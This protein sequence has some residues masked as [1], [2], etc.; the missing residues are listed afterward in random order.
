MNHPTISST[1]YY[2]HRQICVIRRKEK[3]NRVIIIAHLLIV[4]LNI[5]GRKKTW[6]PLRT[7]YLLQREVGTYQRTGIDWFFSGR[8]ALVYEGRHHW[9]CFTV[10]D[11]STKTK[12]PSC[13]T[14][15]LSLSLEWVS[16]LRSAVALNVHPSSSASSTSSSEKVWSGPEW[17]LGSPVPDNLLE[18]PPVI[19][20]LFL[21][22]KK[23]NISAGLV[24]SSAVWTVGHKAQ[25]TG[26]F[27]QA[28]GRSSYALK[29]MEVLWTQ[30]PLSSFTYLKKKKESQ[31]ISIPSWTRATFGQAME[32]LH[33]HTVDAWLWRN[34]ERH[35]G[36]WTEICECIKNKI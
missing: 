27:T 30:P 24:F 4:L 7:V 2:A 29:W 19:E 6:V 21:P 34:P 33:R 1:V 14:H 35:S 17:F 28:K 31:T 3:E 13:R 9:A 32:K 23:L 11:Q 16:N 8:M 12:L 10:R 25:P 22:L 36:V 5:T 26:C 15:T 20:F 18:K